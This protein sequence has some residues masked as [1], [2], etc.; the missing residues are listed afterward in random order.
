MNAKF[1]DGHEDVPKY[2]KNELDKN[3]IVKDPKFSF[4]SE[5]DPNMI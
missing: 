5:E 2:Y 1:N 3:V 4:K